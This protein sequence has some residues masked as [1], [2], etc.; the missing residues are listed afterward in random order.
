LSAANTTGAILGPVFGTSL[1]K[2]TPQTPLLVG[3]TLMLIISVF[4]LTIPAA[5]QAKP[6]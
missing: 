6:A 5:K 3:G 2:I 4:A 1:Y